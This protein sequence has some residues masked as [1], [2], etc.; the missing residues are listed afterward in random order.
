MLYMM[1]VIFIQIVVE[2]LPV[3]SSS[4]VLL[5]EKICIFFGITSIPITQSFDHFLHLATVLIVTIFFRREWMP[6]LKNIVFVKWYWVKK[7]F[8]R[9]GRGSK[10]SDT[11]KTLLNMSC[12]QYGKKDEHKEER[13]V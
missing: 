12:K 6:L 2:S 5:L 3:S 10:L 11:R 7:I 1:L 9:D 4:H 13:S 8:F